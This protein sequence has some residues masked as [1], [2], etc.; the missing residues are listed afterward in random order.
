MIVIYKNN[1]PYEMLEAEEFVEGEYF[2]DI[3]ELMGAHHLDYTGHNH[4]NELS[5][6]AARMVC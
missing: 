6:Q 4:D 3:L 1:Q 5:V 2:A